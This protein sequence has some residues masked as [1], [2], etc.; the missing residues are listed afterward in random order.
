MY[1]LI[2]ALFFGSLSAYAGEKVFDCKSGQNSLEIERI[3]VNDDQA[4]V[5]LG[6]LGNDFLLY[7][8]SKKAED[9]VEYVCRSSELIGDAQII[10][11]TN[12]QTVSIKVRSNNDTRSVSSF[13]CKR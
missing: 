9:S 5:L 1:F 8:E 3:L 6:S 2:A 10:V 7:C 4:S 13:E 11:E 12:A